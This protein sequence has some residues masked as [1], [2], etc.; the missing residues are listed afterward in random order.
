MPASGRAAAGG[1]F[2]DA[3]RSGLARGADSQQ[4]ADLARRGVVGFEGPEY[5][6]VAVAVHVDF[7]VGR[8]QAEQG[9]HAVGE[10]RVE[11]RGPDGE[12]TQELWIADAD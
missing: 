11:Q 2:R 10:H 8:V 3:G 7:V 9:P 6:V 5:R 4:H 1:D 12:V